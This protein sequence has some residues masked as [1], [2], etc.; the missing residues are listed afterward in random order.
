MISGSG[1]SLTNSGTLSTTGPSGSNQV[2]FRTPI[3]NQ[4]GGTVTFGAANTVHDANTLTTNNGTL[5]VADGGHLGLS[6]GSTLTNGSSATLGVAVNGTTHLASGIS[7]P[8]VSLAGTL[9]VTTEGTPAA[10]STFIPIAGQVTGAFSTYSFGP[11]GY[12]VTYPLASV[13]LTTEAVFTTSPTAFAPKENVVIT[14]QL[15]AIANASASTGTYSATVNYG[16]GGGPVAA[17][18]NITGPTGTVTGP[19]QTYTKAGSY[20]VTTSVANTDG[21][22][23]TTDTTTKAAAVTGPT[24]TRFSRTSIVHGKTLTTVVSGTG[25]K[26]GAK[27]TVSNPGVKVVSAKVGKPT[28]THPNPTITLKLSASKTAAHGPF[29]VTITE[30]TDKTTAIGA[31]KVT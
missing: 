1:D 27:V 31:I 11:F 3:T 5:R 6:G 14:P 25:F 10:L 26:A 17:T 2:Y 19:A 8:G 21:T 28:T 24:V 22:T 15:A 29:N 7:G 12:T 20:T 23:D 13:L 4:S 16:D 30:A 18:V 9:S